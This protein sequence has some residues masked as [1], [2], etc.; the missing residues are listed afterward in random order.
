[1]GKV[2]TIEY[3]HPI[4]MKKPFNLMFNIGPFR[5]RAL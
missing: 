3:V 5:R 4:G 2:C 1:M